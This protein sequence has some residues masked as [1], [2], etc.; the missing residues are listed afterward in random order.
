MDAIEGAQEP[1]RGH[2]A[3]QPWLSHGRPARWREF[4]DQD[5]VIAVA[6]RV[7]RGPLSL[8]QLAVD[9][10]RD[11]DRRARVGRLGR[12]VDP[13]VRLVPR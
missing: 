5:P 4:A 8:E 2:G 12:E 13:D 11:L 10:R 9:H 7:Q 6:G 1:Q 3:E